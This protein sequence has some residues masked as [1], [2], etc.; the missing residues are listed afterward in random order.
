M[1]MVPA[2]GGTTEANPVVGPQHFIAPWCVEDDI[3]PKR[4]QG[5]RDVDL[6]RSIAGATNLLYTLSGRQFRTGR[7][8]VRPCAP[9]SSY[10]TQSYLYPYSSMSGYGAAWGFAAGWSWTAVGM[11]WWQNGQDLSELVL[12]GP[13]RRINQVIVDGEDLGGWNP[14]GPGNPNFTLYDGRRLVRNAVQGGN[15]AAS[16]AWPWNQQLQLDLTNP[17]TFAVDY[18]WGRPPPPDG[19]IAAIELSVAVAQALSGDDDTKLPSRVLSVV[20]QGISI[21]VG[22]PLTYIR[23]DLTGLPLCDLFLNA[24]NPAKLRRRS[25]FLAPNTVI[26]RSQPGAPSIEQAY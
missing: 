5:I 8:V 21:A 25:V 2:P 24:Q 9:S 15:G 26:G 13:V 18:E 3:P 22:D 14:G 11:G 7:S 10:G 19:V 17:G 23:E 12:Q 4:V 20:T 6:A 1:T 16:N